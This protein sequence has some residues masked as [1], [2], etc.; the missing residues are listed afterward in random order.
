MSF[1]DLIR[2]DR[3]LA[4]YHY[5]LMESIYLS[6]SSRNKTVQKISAINMRPEEGRDAKISI[7][8][9]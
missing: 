6:A 8:K 9:S 7:P 4:L 5:S 2:Q 3:R 1:R